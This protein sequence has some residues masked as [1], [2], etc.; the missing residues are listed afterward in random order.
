MLAQVQVPVIQNEPD[1][2]PSAESGINVQRNAEPVPTAEDPDSET[3]PTKLRR[4]KRKTAGKHKN[5]F[6]QP[7]TAVTSSIIITVNK[8]SVYLVITTLLILYGLY[9]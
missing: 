2:V 4:T 1:L 7:R 5:K 6:K 8:L 3:I 9:I